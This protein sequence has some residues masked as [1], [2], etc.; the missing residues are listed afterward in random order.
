MTMRRTNIGWAD[1]SGGD[2]N[3]VIR[4]RNCPISEGCANCYVARDFKRYGREMEENTVLYHKKLERLARA[5]WTSGDQP[6]RRGPGSRPI[7]FIADYGD[8]FCD[9]VPDHFIFNVLDVCNMRRS[10]DWVLLTKRPQ[11]MLDVTNDWLEIYGET[12]KLP[13]NIWCLVT[14]EN[15]RRADELIPILLQVKAMVRGAS[16]EPMLDPIYLRKSWL[17]PYDIEHPGYLNWVIVGAESGPDRRP[18][19]PAWAMDLYEQCR[20]AGVP[21]FGKQDSGPRPGV[22]LLLGGREVKEWPRTAI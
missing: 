3:V 22:P 10:A 6:Y 17:Y 15:Q 9:D 12:P 4:G 19:D 16:I 21:F 1:Y 20:A 7:M 14:A 8:L 11:R 18:F 13:R 2:L 5:Q